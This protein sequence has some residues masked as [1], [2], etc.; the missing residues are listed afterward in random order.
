MSKVI[1]IDTSHLSHWAKQ[2]LGLAEANERDSSLRARLMK[3]A[4]SGEVVCPFSVW[5]ISELANYGN[6]DVQ[7][8]AARLLGTLSRARAFRHFLDI[9]ADEIL[10]AVSPGLCS[11][12]SAIGSPS[13]FVPQEAASLGVIKNPGLDT[14][15][16]EELVQ[17]IVRELGAS[18]YVRS[19]AGFSNS[20]HAA[21]VAQAN[22]R[23]A[24]PVEFEEAVRLELRDF[25]ASADTRMQLD[26]AA[27]VAGVATTSIENARTTKELLALGLR[28]V[29]STVEFLAR[30]RMDP[31]RR[32]RPSDPMDIGHLTLMPYCDA[33]LTE[34]HAAA[35]AG[36]VGK[37][38]GVRVI[39][40]RDE[41]TE[42]LDE[43]AASSEA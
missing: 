31:N 1:Y 8:E 34:R 15:S 13:A 33:F 23:R 21:D 12:V 43:I 5:H 25:M 40:K 17:L 32:P 27:R 4:S 38:F 30:R 14:A 37:L 18:E 39:S 28:G 3:L 19:V 41:L 24:S 2:S 10:H 11:S 9:F 26:S 29:A 42:W 35:V 22:E 6:T 7:A 36:P 20:I 16:A